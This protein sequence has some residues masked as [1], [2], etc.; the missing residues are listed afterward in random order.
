MKKTIL[1]FL[2]AVLTVFALASCNGDNTNKTSDNKTAAIK[3]YIVNGSVASEPVQKGNYVV[4]ATLTDDNSKWISWDYENW[5]IKNVD[6]S[7]N[8]TVYFFSVDKLFSSAEELEAAQDISVGMTVGISSYHAGVG[9]GAGIYTVVEE[10]PSH[11][12][13]LE[14]EASSLFAELKPFEVNG[15][16]I[17]T[18]DQFGAYGDGEKADEN[19]IN[20]AFKFPNI[21]VIEFE[22][23]VYMQENTI[24]LNH[25]D[26]RINGKGAE[27]HNRYDRIVVN[28]DLAIS[29]SS[30]DNV[31]ENIILENLTL[32]CTEDT[33][34]GALYNQ[35]DHIQLAA[36][37]VH[38]ITVR[39]CSMLVPQNDNTDPL[40]VASTWMTGAISDIVFE[41]NFLQN[42][43]DSGMGGG[44]WFSAGSGEY[45][46]KNLI[47]RNN[48]VE[49]NSCDEV[50]ALFFGDFENVIVEN[51]YFYTHSHVY[52]DRMSENGIGFGAWAIETHCKN[53]KF[54][55]NEVRMS[56][57]YT[58]FIF[59][60]AESVEISN[61]KIYLTTNFGD[62]PDVQDTTIIEKAIFR[63]PEYNKYSVTNSKIFGNYIEVN[64]GEYTQNGYNLNALTEGMSDSVEYYDNEYVLNCIV[65]K[66]IG[67][68]DYSKFYNNKIT[69]NGSLLN[70]NFSD[71]AKNA[72]QII[73]NQ[74]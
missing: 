48:H 15:E 50:F 4:Y 60:Q 3:T 52:P 23:S 74:K 29:G 46:C 30:A 69:I 71:E 18:V 6:D 9:R 51:N 73:I 42:F 34:K 20:R 67:E 24:S 25:G 32:K 7:L 28:Q 31:I 47:V 40:Q 58:P 55:G 33:G 21:D 14:I 45:G 16:K 70:N 26:V 57:R 22:S 65:N 17:I 11:Q 35:A 68:S 1:L 41:N 36:S 72:N 12:G 19:K 39:N 38:F 61:N 13:R 43:S 49:K 62:Q 10:K 8:Y 2:V 54:S 64:C 59:S 66:F 56:V 63:L 37:N 5:C 53:V 44:L 27:I